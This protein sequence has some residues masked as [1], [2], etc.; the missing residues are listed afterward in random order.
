M[1]NLFSLET[2]RSVN[3]EHA[4]TS[5]LVGQPAEYLLCPG[6]GFRMMGP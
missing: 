1:Q 4:E 6:D 2:A 5:E 3:A